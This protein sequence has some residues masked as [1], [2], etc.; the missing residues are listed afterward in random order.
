MAL[1]I[2]TPAFRGLK[3][4]HTPLII[5]DVSNFILHLIFCWIPF[6]WIIACSLRG[7][8]STRFNVTEGAIASHSCRRALIKSCLLEIALDLTFA[9]RT[10]HIC[11]IGLMSGD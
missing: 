4:I 6:A 1:N 5:R 3:S 8:D 9:S 11:S 7:M 10:S 2:T